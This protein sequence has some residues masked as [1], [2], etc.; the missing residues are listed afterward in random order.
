MDIKEIQLKIRYYFS[1]IKLKIKNKDTLIWQ[2]C[3][4]NKN[5]YIFLLYIPYILRK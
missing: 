5:F 1:P 2:E 4:E 3:G